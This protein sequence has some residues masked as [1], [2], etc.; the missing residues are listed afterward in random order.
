MSALEKDLSVRLNVTNLS[1]KKP[2]YYNQD[3][4]FTNGF[5][6]GRFMQIGISNLF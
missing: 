4:G 1:D 6:L 5:T 2:P 3:A